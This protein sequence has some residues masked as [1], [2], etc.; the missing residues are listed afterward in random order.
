[1]AT[2]LDAASFD[3]VRLFGVL[4]APMLPLDRLLPEMH[5]VLKAQG[6]PAVRPPLIGWLPQSIV[7]SGLFTFTGRRNGVHNFKRD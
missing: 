6:I 5:R 1:M 2:G 3:A 7:Q 4:P